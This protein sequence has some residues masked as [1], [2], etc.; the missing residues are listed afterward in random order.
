[1]TTLDVSIGAARGR[2]WIKPSGELDLSTADDLEKRIREIEVTGAP[3]IVL[4]LRGITFMDSTGLRLVIA[5]DD[6]ARGDGRSLLLVKGPENV[7][8][9]FRVAL[10]DRRLDFIDEGEAST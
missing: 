9:V 6:R 1:M 10:L 3:E 4:D 8:R 5:A 2:T 7:H